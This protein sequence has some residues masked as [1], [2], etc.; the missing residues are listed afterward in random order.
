MEETIEMDTVIENEEP[1]I[2]PLSQQIHNLLEALQMVQQVYDTNNAALTRFE[3]LTQDYLHA[4]ELEATN[5][6]ERARIATALQRCRQVRR[7]YKKQVYATEQVVAY[8]RSAAGQRLLGQLEHLGNTAR[9]GER[10]AKASHYAPRI[11]SRDEYKTATHSN[12]ATAY[13][14]VQRVAQK[15]VG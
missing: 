14:I 5:Y 1:V 4:I 12:T 6:H 9:N 7:C 10:L 3:K 11:L 2:I 13:A 15:E 8:L